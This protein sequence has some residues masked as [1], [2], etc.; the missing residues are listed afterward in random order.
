MF[1]LH[2]MKMR[3][4]CLISEALF[5]LIGRLLPCYGNGVSRFKFSISVETIDGTSLL[6]VTLLGWCH[7]TVLSLEYQGK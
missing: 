4:R 6:V 2:R 7:V 1:S 5:T 3:L